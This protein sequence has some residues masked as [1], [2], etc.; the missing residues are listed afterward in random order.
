MR[1]MKKVT[2][3]G[4]GGPA[5]LAFNLPGC[6]DARTPR[7]QCHIGDSSYEFFKLA[8]ESLVDNPVHSFGQAQM[9][10]GVL[11][12]LM[13]LCATHGFPHLKTHLP[14]RATPTSKSERPKTIQE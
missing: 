2:A 10:D 13:T 9:F 5:I 4:D 11:C 14:K 8:E 3:K 1:S 6:V 12:S 7:D